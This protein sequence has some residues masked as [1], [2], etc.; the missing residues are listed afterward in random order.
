MDDD[1]IS[2]TKL[3]V[4]HLGELQKES[5]NLSFMKNPKDVVYHSFQ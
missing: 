4:Y 3:Y 5:N 1:T 2:N